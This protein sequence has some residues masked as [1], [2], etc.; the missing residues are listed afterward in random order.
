M[1]H[2][3]NCVIIDDDP[4]AV[5][6][7]IEYIDQ[8][9]GLKLAEVYFDPLLALHELLNLHES[10]IVF[11]DIH[12]PKF[13]GIQLAQQL[14]HKTF[15]II[16]TTGDD[17]Q[18]QSAFDVNARK[19]LHKPFEL[20]KFVSAVSDVITLPPPSPQTITGYTPVILF[21]RTGERGKLTKVKR[22]D[23]ILV[24]AMLNY[25]TIATPKKSYIVYMTLTEMTEIL[26][27]AFGFFRVHK[28]FLINIH[29]IDDLAGNTIYLGQH[30]VLMSASY[31]KNFTRFVAKNTLNSNRLNGK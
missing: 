11:L 23:I 2:L 6:L 16:F 20:P 4:S 9:P 21:L 24:K 12:M 26:P 3:T 17:Q 22:E 10:L 28:S 5:D 8:V 19:Y 27:E 31:K 14:K 13:S 29:H 18:M 25:V 7:L 1:N 15:Q 30:E